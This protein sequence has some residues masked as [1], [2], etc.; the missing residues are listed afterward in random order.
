[1]ESIM[2]PPLNAAVSALHAFGQKL[3]V[4]AGNIANVNTDGYKKYRAIFQ[5]GQHGA[6]EVT[7]QRDE[8]GIALGRPEEGAQPVQKASNVALEEE[9]PGLIVSVY[10]FKANLKTLKAQDEILGSL[11]DAVA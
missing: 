1:M 10:G 5:E 8:T 6:V 11:L 4:T 3:G 9:F 7:E 2:I